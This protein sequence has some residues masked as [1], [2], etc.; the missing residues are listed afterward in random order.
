M[1]DIITFDQ[2]EFYDQTLRVIAALRLPFRALDNVEFRRLIKMASLSNGQHLRLLVPSTARQRLNEEIISGYKDI[3]EQLPS[4]AKISLAL[5]GWS[6]PN[7][8]HFQA[9]TG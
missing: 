6:S 3:L 8:I 9:I 4:G 7:N 2:E 1:K 5:D